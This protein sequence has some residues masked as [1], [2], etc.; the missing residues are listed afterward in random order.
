MFLEIIVCISNTN[1][2]SPLLFVL[3]C[4]VKRFSA[5]CAKYCQNFSTSSLVNFDNYFTFMGL[6]FMPNN[7]C[8]DLILRIE[9]INFSQGFNFAK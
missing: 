4:S 8:G 5:F 7:F 3:F 1:S 6:I 9:N 2:I